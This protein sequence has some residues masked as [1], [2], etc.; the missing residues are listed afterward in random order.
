VHLNRA[1]QAA[2]IWSDADW[3]RA[4]EQL[5]LKTYQVTPA[6]CKNFDKIFQFLE[7]QQLEDVRS[8]AT[9][10][11]NIFSQ[12]FAQMKTAAD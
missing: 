7:Q 10:P 2:T 4:I 6:K 9:G 1:R 5:V 8:K 12:G 3:Q 11:R